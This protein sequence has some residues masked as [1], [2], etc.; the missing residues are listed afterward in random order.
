MTE[1]SSSLAWQGN[2]DD[3]LV[4]GQFLWE[5]DNKIDD[6]NYSTEAKKVK[7]LRNNIAYGSEADEWFDNLDPATETDTYNH[8]TDMFA[9][10]WPLTA[11]PKASK[12]EHIQALK[13]WVL[14]QTELGKKVEGPGGSQIWSHV[15]WA[16]GL[17]AKV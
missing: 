11:V 6:Q 16:T 12:A 10:Q 3:N 2:G 4:P 17:A 1:H 8:L 15:K 5:I 13:D 9:K 14:K 7:C